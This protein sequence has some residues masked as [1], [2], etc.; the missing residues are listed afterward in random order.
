MNNDDAYSRNFSIG[1]DREL[2]NLSNIRN[3]DTSHSDVEF[4]KNMD[5]SSYD[6]H[7][8]GRTPRE[9]RG[10]RTGHWAS[11]FGTVAE[12]LESHG[13]DGADDTPVRKLKQKNVTIGP[14]QREYSDAYLE[15]NLRT[16]RY[17][18]H[19]SYEGMLENLD[20]EDPFDGDYAPS[21]KPKYEMRKSQ[22][23]KSP[24]GHTKIPVPAKD[25]KGNTNQSFKL[26]ETDK[27]S[28][29]S[30]GTFTV[31]E[32]G[33]GKSPRSTSR[34]SAVFNRSRKSRKSKRTKMGIDRGI[35]TRN[36]HIPHFHTDSTA[37]L[38]D[39]FGEIMFVGYGHDTDKSPYIR[40]SPDT[41]PKIMYDMMINIWEL[42]HPQLLISVTGG[43]KGLI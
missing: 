2:D 3:L 6:K 11:E 38:C 32:I 43:A 39:S 37:E 27:A 34:A 7:R 30:N 1:S 31:P 8:E 5:S 4:R 42:S 36:K 21:G 33:Y 24:E 25:D 29:K 41:S 28:V 26:A 35:N 13:K 19:T 22:K 40:V 9:G 10:P 14:V 20:P 12:T 17:N 16:P 15:S 18:T 23:D